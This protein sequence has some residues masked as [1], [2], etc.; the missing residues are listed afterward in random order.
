MTASNIYSKLPK[1]NIDSFR[2]NPKLLLYIVFGFSAV[3]LILF[4]SLLIWFATKDNIPNT[5]QNPSIST[6]PEL[7]QV[8]STSITPETSFVESTKFLYLKTKTDNST[9][10]IVSYDLKDNKT[11]DL[12]NSESVNSIIS[13]SPNN[14][15]LFIGKKNNST[16]VEYGIFNIET[17]SYTVI[18]FGNYIQSFWASNEFLNLLYS[19]EIDNTYSV[20]S[21]DVKDYTQSL[22]LSIPQDLV[23]EPFV[24]KDLKYLVGINKSDDSYHFFDL[25]LKTDHKISTLDLI[26][27]TPFSPLLWIN[28]NK[29]IYISGSGIFQF[30]PQLL[31]SIQLVGLTTRNDNLEVKFLNYNE[32]QNSLLFMLD[33]Y[34]YRFS[35]NTKILKEILN[36]NNKSNIKL[37]D[38]EGNG[39][40]YF[41]MGNYDG[42]M[43]VYNIKNSKLAT[44]CES[45]CR[46]PIWF[47]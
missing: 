22:L 8:I 7:T 46:N 26:S 30:N 19:N 13:I 43:E 4:I 45:S 5:N 27:G 3:V 37:V 16:K 35:L 38:L 23:I 17:K 25:A 1:I 42:M 31:N 44:I 28:S 9:V 10:S 2:N 29:L 12:Y 33:G 14:K 20:Y 32:D 36:V 34:I 11:E 15:Y 21:I 18:K 6:T 40:S 41:I 24:S 47:Y 39:Q